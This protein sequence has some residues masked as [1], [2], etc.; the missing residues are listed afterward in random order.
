[1]LATIRIW[2]FAVLWQLARCELILGDVDYW[3]QL[4]GA[5]IRRDL[6]LQ[7]GFLQLKSGDQ[8]VQES[9]FKIDLDEAFDISSN[10]RTPK[11]AAIGDNAQTSGLIGQDGYMFADYDEFYSYAY[12]VRTRRATSQLTY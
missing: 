5:V 6:Y 3:E 4:Q 8:Y 9:L 1:M 12:R 2:A 10:D 11:L 7:G